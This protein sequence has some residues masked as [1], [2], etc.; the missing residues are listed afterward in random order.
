MF[1]DCSEFPKH[2][3]KKKKYRKSK[4]DFVPMEKVKVLKYFHECP[5]FVGILYILEG[6]GRAGRNMGNL[7]SKDSVLH[8]GFSSPSHKKGSL[9]CLGAASTVNC[10]A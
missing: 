4:W 3:K 8:Q 6:E 9:K 5:S 2:K 10:R 7:F 1:T